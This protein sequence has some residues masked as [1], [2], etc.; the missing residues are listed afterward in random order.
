MALRPVVVQ[1]FPPGRRHRALVAWPHKLI[2]ESTA[3]TVQ[4]YDLVADPRELVNLADTE[5]D[6]VAA[7]RAALLAIEAD[8]LGTPGL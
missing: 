6:R 1:C 8:A 3:G 5:P 2:V 4:L 7:L